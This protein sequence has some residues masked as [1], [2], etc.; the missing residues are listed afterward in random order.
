MVRGVTDA[1]DKEE[2][3]FVVYGRFG[4]I[5]LILISQIFII[6]SS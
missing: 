5:L 6:S 3:M 4:G 1:R 2:R